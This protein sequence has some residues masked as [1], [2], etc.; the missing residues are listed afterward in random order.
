[1]NIFRQ[2]LNQ[3]FKS[4]KIISRFNFKHHQT[5]KLGDVSRPEVEVQ[6]WSATDKEWQRYSML[7]DTG[8]DYT[9]LPRYIASMLGVKFNRTQLRETIGLGGAQKVFF[10]PE[11]RMKIGG[12]ERIIP[13]GFVDSNQV[14]P[15]L[16]R[17]QALET[18][19]VVLNKKKDIFFAE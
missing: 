14:P 16:G 10:I 7:I 13:V 19:V 11:V 4:E 8:A 12:V 15:L 17:H 1:M 9:L 3:I 5:A 2:T 18:F 6:L